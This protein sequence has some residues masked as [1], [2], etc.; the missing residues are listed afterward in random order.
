MIS[1]PPPG[2]SSQY[3]TQLQEQRSESQTVVKKQE[4]GETLVRI[5]VSS[6][7]NVSLSG[8]SSKSSL[9]YFPPKENV[10]ATEAVA[11]APELTQA[12]SNI[13][14]F[15]ELR[16]AQEAADGATPEELAERLEQGLKGFIQ[17][18]TEAYEQIAGAGLLGP[19]VEAAI[20]STYNQVL[21]GVAAL[22][23][24]FEV[25]PP[26]ALEEYKSATKAVAS[27]V[28]AEPVASSVDS[29]VVDQ[30]QIQSLSSPVD[31][32][33]R[34]I[35]ASAK[36]ALDLSRMIE[37]SSFNYE[38]SEEREFAFKLK[39]Q[40]GDEVTIFAFANR[41]TSVSAAAM[42]YNDPGKATSSVGF[43]AASSEQ[44]V[45]SFR[46]DGELD[47]SEL[48]AIN[49]LLNQVGNISAA[50]FSGNI[51][52]AFELA[53][54]LGFDESEIAQFSLNLS[55]SV[56]TK[57]QAAY[58]QVAE[59]PTLL[60]QHESEKL[61]ELADDRNIEML[62]KFVEMLREA[63]ENARK[64]GVERNVIPRLAEQVAQENY[65]GEAAAERINSVIER[66]L[67]N[68]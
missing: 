11:D 23:E 4:A 5:Q 9:T 45:F 31:I 48:K 63:A 22:A 10:S 47:E 30:G 33:K 35:E 52:E 20:Q 14:A 6:S 49:G 64:L 42:D 21:E 68:L 44:N 54:E 26:K 37:A 51:N 12:A 62:A 53:L 34:G 17:G 18:Y 60:E 65:A 32:V 41:N 8:Y 36:S 3:S 58:A 13:L 61:P 28:A 15:I 2:Q 43:S 55:Q 38:R 39:T 67:G 7:S 56:S 24:R 57:A 66:L 29:P 40:D 19:E 59:Q 27:N 1:F 46:V 50:F 25:E 16:I